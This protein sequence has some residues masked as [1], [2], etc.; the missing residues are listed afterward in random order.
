MDEIYRLKEEVAWFDRID[1]NTGQRQTGSEAVKL[2]TGTEFRIARGK[3]DWEAEPG[4]QAF[5]TYTI[6]V[7]GKHYNVLA[8]LLEPAME[9]VHPPAP[10]SQR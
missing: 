7:K 4:G 9:R 6:A 8:I 3:H 2:P 5:P 1:E 10:P